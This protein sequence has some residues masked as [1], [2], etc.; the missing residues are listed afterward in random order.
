MFSVADGD[1]NSNI[2]FSR[3]LPEKHG[4]SGDKCREPRHIG[5][6]AK[7]LE[8][9]PYR[10]RNKPVD[11]LAPEAAKLRTWEVGRKIQQRDVGKLLHPVFRLPLRSAGVHPFMQP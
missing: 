7:L 3:L 8:R 1:G 5:G 4:I 6:E 10:I 2:A 9:F 11:A